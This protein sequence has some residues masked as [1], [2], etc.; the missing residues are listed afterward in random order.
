MFFVAA[1]LL[2]PII[3]YFIL[4]LD[5]KYNF[6]NIFAITPWRVFLLIL[7]IPDLLV[8]LWFIRL[9]ESPKYYMARGYPKKALAVLQKMYSANYGKCREFFPVKN[10]ISEVNSGIKNNEVVIT[11][12]TARVL[13]EILQQI[14]RLFRAPLLVKTTLT[15][16]IMFC[17]MFG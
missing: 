10:I 9:P 1:W 17:N 7:A 3:A 4:P 16:G 12:K 14:K 8:G 15:T 13:K 6:R 2:L 5:I 11:G